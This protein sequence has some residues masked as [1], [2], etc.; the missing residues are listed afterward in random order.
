MNRKFSK[1]LFALII[2]ELYVF[3]FWNYSKRSI[4]ETDN[5]LF[6]FRFMFILQ[7]SKTNN[8]CNKKDKQISVIEYSIDDLLQILLYKNNTQNTIK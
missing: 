1:I 4:R 3:I 7:R 8:R 6:L 5:S 2:I